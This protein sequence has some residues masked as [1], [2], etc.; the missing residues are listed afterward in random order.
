MLRGRPHSADTDDARVAAALAQTATVDWASAGAGTVAGAPDDAMPWISEF[1]ASP[2]I[3]AAHVEAADADPMSPAQTTT[4]TMDAVVADNAVTKSAATESDVIGDA[5]TDDAVMD[6]AASERAA[7]D[8]AATYFAPTEPGR[9]EDWPF[10]DAGAQAS[11]LSIEL[12][13]PDPFGDALLTGA[14]P[15]AL[16]M[17]NDDDMMDI[18]PVRSA[19]LDEADR[20]ATQAAEQQEHSEAAARALEGLAARV[21]GGELALPG[22]ASEMGDAA[23]LAAALA[24]LLGVRH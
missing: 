7:S 15:A 23:A 6:N 14:T 1:L 16:P 9:A 3:D 18:M 22:Y 24:A 8:A 10:A 20:E 19:S 13:S 4:V 2:G 21:R 17:W 11:E 12:P 5:A